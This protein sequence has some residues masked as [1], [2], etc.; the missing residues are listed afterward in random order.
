[1]NSDPLMPIIILNPI[2][3]GRVS[4]YIVRLYPYITEGAFRMSK[5]GP[6]RNNVRDTSAADQ[7]QYHSDER[8]IDITVDAQTI[9][10][11]L[12]TTMHCCKT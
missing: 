9:L 3:N 2:L 4:T 12:I 1:M 11:L 10:L 6:D 8:I 5:L 7:G